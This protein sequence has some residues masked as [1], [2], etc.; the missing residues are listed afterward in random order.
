[1]A[2]E[3]ASTLWFAETARLLARTAQRL[4]CRAPGFRSPPR[5]G[6]CDRTIR[7]RSTGVTV[8][9]RVRGRP[10]VA[11]LADMIEGIV[12]ANRRSGSRAV[13]LRAA[14]W[15]AAGEHDAPTAAV[16]SEVA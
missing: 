3:P 2:M 14:L 16:S 4:G 9:V 10:R 12:V 7:R 8:A 13:E 1:M 6:G 5:L 15:A 11:V